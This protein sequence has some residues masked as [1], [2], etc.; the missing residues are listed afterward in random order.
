MIAGRPGYGVTAG[1]IRFRGEEITGK[2][3]D[4]RAR[5]GLFLA[6]QYPVEVPGVSVVNFLRTAY[7]AIKGGERADLEK[8]E[9]KGRSHAKH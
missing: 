8:A 6:M 1:S 4:E 5:L 3:A 2:S 7:Q 9:E